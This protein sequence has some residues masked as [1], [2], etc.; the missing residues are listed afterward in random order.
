MKLINHDYKSHLAFLILKMSENCSTVG[1][2]DIL[3]TR[4]RK[5]MVLKMAKYGLKNMLI[6]S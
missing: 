3:I 6:W 5:F 1:Q 2:M 4:P